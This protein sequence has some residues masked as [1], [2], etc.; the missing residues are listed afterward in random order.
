[1]QRLEREVKPAS[2]HRP[3]YVR[4][5]PRTYGGGGGDKKSPARGIISGMATVECS[6]CESVWLARNKNIYR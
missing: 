5:H 1:M 6:V 3:A 4:A 2:N